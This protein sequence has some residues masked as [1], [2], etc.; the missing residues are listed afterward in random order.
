[1]LIYFIFV[2]KAE[3]SLSEVLEV[4]QEYMPKE[5]NP[6]GSWKNLNIN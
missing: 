1:M 6:T 3:E 4:K 5:K 2:K